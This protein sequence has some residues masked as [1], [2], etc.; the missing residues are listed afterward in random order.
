M[1]APGTGKKRKTKKYLL[2]RQK[3]Q[4]LINKLIEETKSK[5]S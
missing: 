5:K 2:K 3:Q 1:P 4:Q